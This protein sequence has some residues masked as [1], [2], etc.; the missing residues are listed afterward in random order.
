MVQSLYI[1]SIQ[2]GYYTAG[3]DRKEQKKVRK[4]ALVK[5]QDAFQYLEGIQYQSQ[6]FYQISDQGTS[7]GK[8]RGDT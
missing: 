5:K 8:G 2:R 6:A 4:R 3:K 7:G 1:S